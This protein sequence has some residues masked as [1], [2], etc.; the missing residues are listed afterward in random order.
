[1]PPTTRPLAAFVVCALAVAPTAAPAQSDDQRVSAFLASDSNGDR[2]LSFAEFNVLVG[3]LA[4]SGFRLPILV[5]SLGAY[6]QAFRR[7]DADQNG[8]ATPEELL[9]AEQAFLATGH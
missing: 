5:E 1:M 6:H 8:L 4:R 9:A 7:V 3:H 2:Q